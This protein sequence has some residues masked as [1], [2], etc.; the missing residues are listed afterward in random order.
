MQGTVYKCLVGGLQRIMYGSSNRVQIE[1]I[2]GMTMR[3]KE[4]ASLTTSQR[5][6]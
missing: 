6:F 1:D 3:K 5:A 4:G 2:Q